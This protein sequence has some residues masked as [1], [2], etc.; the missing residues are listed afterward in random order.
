MTGSVDDRDRPG[1][2]LR[3]GR[4][5]LERVI[6]VGGMA[7][8]WL[9]R[10]R[11]LDR[12]VAVKLLSDNLASDPDYVRRF[13]RE[14]RTA[15]GLSHPNLVKVFDFEPEGR[16]ALIMEYVE[17]GT[18]EDRRTPS[19]GR[20]RGARVAAARG[21][22]AHPCRRDRPPRRQARQRP[23]RGRRPRDAD[24]LRDRAARGRDPDDADRPGPRDARLHGARDAGGRAR[25]A[26]IRPLLVRRRPARPPR[27][28]EPRPPSSGSS[29]G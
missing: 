27:A 14:A 10:D 12:P 1:A 19:G 20:R 6:G 7:A 17:G 15:A 9:G 18:L 4:Y 28:R 5:R 16:P 2:E 29:S 3:D 23:D 22:R 24:R 26:A 13:N 21:A 25:D 8:V 11:R